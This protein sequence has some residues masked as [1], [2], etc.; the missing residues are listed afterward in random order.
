MFKDGDIYKMHT[1]KDSILDTEGAYVLY[2]G[3]VT[4]R[5]YESNTVIPSVGAFCLTPGED[6]S[7]EDELEIFIKQVVKALLYYQG[8][9]TLDFNSLNY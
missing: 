8:L 7:E 3:D 4:K 6:D 2:P 9:I 1:Y 5:F